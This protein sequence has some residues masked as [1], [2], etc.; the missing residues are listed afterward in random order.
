[1]TR[2]TLPQEARP[3]TSREEAEQIETAA[4]HRQQHMLPGE[5]PHAPEKDP[6]VD[7][8]K[9]EDAPVILGP[10]PEPATYTDAPA[11]AKTDPEDRDEG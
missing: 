1:M 9:G 4:R 2:T 10:A 3:N 6:Q 5:G 11:A 8:C 7:H